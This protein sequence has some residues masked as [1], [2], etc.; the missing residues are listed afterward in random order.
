MAIWRVKAVLAAALASLV[1][2]SAAARGPYGSINVGA[3]QGGAY[4]NDQTG[5]F[6]HCAAG[7][8]YNSGIFFIV[9]VDSAMGWTLGFIHPEWTLSN[10]QVFQVALTFDGGTPFNVQGAVTGNS[11]V[12]V[13]M[14]LNSA[15]INQFRK[16]KS[17]T[18]YTQGRLFQFDLKQTSVLLPAL[19]NCVH[20]VQKSGLNSAGDFTVNVA[21]RHAAAGPAGSSLKPDSGA[22]SSA[23]LQIEAIE[24]ASNFIMK[25]ALHGAKVL[26]RAETPQEIAA[27]GAAWRSEEASGFVRIVPAQPNIKGLDVAAAVVGNDAKG[28]KGKFASAR[29]S[30]LVDSDVVFQGFSSCEDSDGAWLANYFIVPRKR[31]GFILFS[32]LSNMK[33]EQARNVTKEEKIGDFRKAALVA[34]GP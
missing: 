30:E 19:V 12:R 27:Y 25:S 34:T 2:T 26:S 14:P 8:K 13:P 9:G 5:A 15:L 3:W 11:M 7:A 16:A 6:S 17:M 21:P 24:L 23:E 1:A 4:T 29:K 18:A 33:S 32:V 31:G 20:T 10:G 22:P 28:C